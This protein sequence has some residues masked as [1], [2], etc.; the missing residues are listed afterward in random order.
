M[1]RKRNNRKL[2]KPSYWIFRHRGSSLSL[3]PSLP[4]P[5]LPQVFSLSWRTE[6]FH[7]TGESHMLYLGTDVHTWL[8]LLCTALEQQSMALTEALCWSSTCSPLACIM[9]RTSGREY[10]CVTPWMDNDKHAGKKNDDVQTRKKRNCVFFFFFTILTKALYESGS[11][12]VTSSSWYFTTGKIIRL[13]S[14]G[15]EWKFAGISV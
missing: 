10:M 8:T 14:F 11:R 15:S 4:L 7:T 3:W 13:F 9:K 2:K 5:F 1:H 12:K 6:T